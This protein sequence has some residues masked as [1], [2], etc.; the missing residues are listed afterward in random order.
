MSE[1]YNDTVFPRINNRI[2]ELRNKLNM[3][4]EEFGKRIGLSKSGIS[5]IEKGVRGISERHIMLICS[6]FNVNDSWLR[7]G[8]DSIKKLSNNVENLE[9]LKNYL[10]SIGYIMTVEKTG[11]SELGYCEEN[12]DDAGNIIN[13]T[14]I[15]DEEYFSIILTK[16]NSTTEFTEEEFKE[17]KSTI[18]KSIEFEVFKQNQ[19]N[20]EKK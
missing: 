10:K 14:F 4:Q 6:T 19:K 20:K 2:K 13:K 9:Q 8:E 18:E 7:T 12:Q 3:T 15:P 16:D 11:Q 1:I 5:N 17:F